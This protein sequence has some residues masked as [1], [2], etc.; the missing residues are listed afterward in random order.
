MVRGSYAPMQNVLITKDTP[1]GALK[2]TRKF[3]PEIM[4]REKLKSWKATCQLSFQ[5]ELRDFVKM[6]GGTYDTPIADGHAGL[7]AV[8]IAAAVH[9]STRTGNVVQLE[10]IGAMRS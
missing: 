1:D 7:R 4:V 5:D 9:E 2:K 6:V 10:N 8:E 3:Y